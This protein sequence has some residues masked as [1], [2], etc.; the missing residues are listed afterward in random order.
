M[1]SDLTWNTWRSHAILED[2]IPKY[3]GDLGKPICSQL[4]NQ[5]ANGKIDL[6]MS[7][8]TSQAGHAWFT[9]DT[10]W[11]MLRL[12]GV[13]CDSPTRF[14]RRSTS[15]DA[16]VDRVLS[17]AENLVSTTNGAAAGR[18]MLRLVKSGVGHD[19]ATIDAKRDLQMKFLFPV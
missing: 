17:A 4:M 8:F 16:P 13:E 18:S 10:F 3:D 7:G 5:P 11:A 6:L 15:E 19:P 9:A 1:I 2:E 14:A 12:R